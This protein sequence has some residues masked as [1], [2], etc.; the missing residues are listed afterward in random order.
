MA[1]YA[2]VVDG[3]V[4]K[5]IVGPDENRPAPDGFGSWEDYF[6]A[7]GEGKVLRTSYNT[8]GGVHYEENT[9][10][11]SA[12]QS[13]A[14]RYNYAGIGYTYDEERDAFIAPSPAPS[15]VLNEQTLLWE[16]P[17]PKPDNGLYSWNEET[18][19]WVP[20]AG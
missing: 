18:V 16:P 15:W 9:D 6:S 5:V 12:D 19:S 8:F 13:L 14:L 4:T 2:F 20:Y 1:H 7:R 10:I 17:I 11:P 3:I